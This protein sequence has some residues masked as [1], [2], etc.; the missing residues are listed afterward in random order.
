[1]GNSGYMTVAE[2]AKICG[3]TRQTVNLWIQKKVIAA[4]KVGYRVYI[5]RKSL[6]KYL[7]PDAARILAVG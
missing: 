3:V 7:G 4:V 2:V 5:E 1:M 6:L